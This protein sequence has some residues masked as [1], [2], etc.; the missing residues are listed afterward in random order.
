M[1]QG[2][3]DL[4]SQFKFLWPHLELFNVGAIDLDD[5]QQLKQANRSIRPFFVRTTKN[6]LGL[7]KPTIRYRSVE[8]GPKQKEAWT[9]LKDESARFIAGLNPNDKAELRTI[10][11]Q[12]M[13]VLQFC[14]DPQLLLKQLPA[15][16]RGGELF[17]RLKGLSNDDS[18][19]VKLLDKLVAQTMAKPGE[20]VVIWSMFVDQIERL[21]DRYAEYGAISIHGGVPTGSDEDLAFREARIARF[22]KNT[23]CRILVANPAACGEGISLHR[24]AHHAIYFDRSFNAA[25]FLQSIDRIHR[26]GLPAGTKTHIDIICL[27]DSIEVAVRTRLSQK[28]ER[29]QKMLDDDDLSAMVYDPEDVESIGEDWMV[30]SSD[31]NSVM[32]VLRS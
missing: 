8:M 24:A 26:R 13:R 6:E 16:Y 11:K 28:I 25:H 19:K 7:E 2:L 29:L 32:K 5:A 4:V 10:G 27:E 20:K 22:K 12:I 3:P 18:S 23:D 31:I 1:P 21:K 30:E 9:L 15:S 14:S 17:N